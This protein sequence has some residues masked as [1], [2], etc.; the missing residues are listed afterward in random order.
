VLTQTLSTKA[1]A[2]L[3]C[4]CSDRAGIAQISVEQVATT[5]E[6]LSLFRL[7]FCIVFLSIYSPV[8][9]DAQSTATTNKGSAY[10]A[11]DVSIN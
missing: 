4:T 11:W 9:L 6:K 3:A 5:T 2:L 7:S 1:S 10:F 8:F